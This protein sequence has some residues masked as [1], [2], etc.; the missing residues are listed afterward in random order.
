MRVTLKFVN[1]PLNGLKG[2]CYKVPRKNINMSLG[3]HE[4]FRVH[5]RI[6]QHT[7]NL[8]NLSDVQYM[9]TCARIISKSIELKG[10]TNNEKS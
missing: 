2:Q 9:L 8:D 7:K 3:Q 4:E 10:V 5:R 6:Y 1:I